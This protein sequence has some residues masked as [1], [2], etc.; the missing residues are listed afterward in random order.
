MSTIEDATNIAI[1]GVGAGIALS[2]VM[3][4]IN[5]MNKMGKKKRKKGFK[6]PKNM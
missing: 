1:T 5:A 3:V 4:P 6:M 2:A